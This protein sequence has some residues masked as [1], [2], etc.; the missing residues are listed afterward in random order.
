MVIAGIN[1]GAVLSSQGLGSRCVH[2]AAALWFWLEC[3]DPWAA[4]EEADV[5]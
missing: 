1:T 3:E 2:L 5:F 4:Q